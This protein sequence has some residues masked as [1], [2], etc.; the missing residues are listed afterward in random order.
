MDSLLITGG[1]EEERIKKAKRLL[2]DQEISQFDTYNLYPEISIGIAEV[3]ELSQWLNLKPYQ[4][5]KKAAIIFEAEKLTIEAQSALLKNLE[6]PPANTFIIL[7]TPNADVLLP[8][9][10]SRCQL[11][12]LSQKPQILLSEKEV[13]QLLNHLI[14][15][16]SDDIGEKFKLC[17][18]IE[19]SREEAIDWLNKEITVL[20]LLLKNE[21]LKTKK[22]L[23]LSIPVS[24]Y[25]IIIHQFQKTKSYIQ[26]K[27]NTRLS[28][29]NLFLTLPK[30]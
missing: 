28:L 3:R 26:A 10:V 11:I 9:I 22:P 1:T 21:T 17:Q 8:T 19:K 2:I 12:N 7:V 25:P 24:R 29:E 13:A 15:L 27:A 6:E 23:F 30:V 20:E 14:I 18:E 5:K 16:F 4:S